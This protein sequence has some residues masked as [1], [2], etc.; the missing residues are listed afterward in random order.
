MAAFSFA[1]P[2]EDPG[3][4]LVAA[5]GSAN[6]DLITLQN[7]LDEEVKA[8]QDALISQEEFEKLRNGKEN[9]IISAYSSVAGIAENLAQN[10]MYMG[11]TALINSEL[12]KYMAVTREDIQ[13]VA[14]KYFTPENRVILYYL[15]K[16]KN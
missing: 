4:G 2:L 6:V 7:A 12:T 10:Y 15:P 14:K 1:F 5:I 8:V 13:R 9:D 16:P 11:S 3:L